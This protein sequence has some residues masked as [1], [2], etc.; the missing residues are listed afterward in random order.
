MNKGKAAYNILL[1]LF[2][3]GNLWICMRENF[4]TRGFS[5]MPIAVC[6][7]L[8]PPQGHCFCYKI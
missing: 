6:K 3:E 4:D 2:D 7:S 1:Y 5:I 8:N